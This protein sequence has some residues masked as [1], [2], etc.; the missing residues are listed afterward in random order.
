MRAEHMGRAAA[1]AMIL[2]CAVPVVAGADG[3]GTVAADVF[4]FGG[5]ARIDA[6]A[7]G[8]ALPG[9]A[10]ALIRNPAAL[11]DASGTTV[12]VDYRNWYL[13][14]YA[15]HA[16]V[17]T[18]AFWGRG[19]L[20]VGV[21]RLSEGEVRDL[22]YQHLAY[23]E[24]FDN[25]SL[26]IAVG[27]GAP[28]PVLERVDAGLS[29]LF[30]TR[31]LLSQ[32][33][34]GLGVGGGLAAGLWDDALRLGGSFRHIGDVEGDIEGISN[35]SPWSVTAG[36][37]VTIDRF[38]HPGASATVTADVVKERN[39]DAG[40][41]VGLEVE[42][43]EALALRVGYDSMVEDAPVRFGLGMRG[44]RADVGLVYTHHEALGSTAGLSVTLSLG[45]E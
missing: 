13:D 24:A 44:G 36:A 3:V 7:A 1:I 23:G 32:T 29:A 34:S 2:T 4:A 17:T 33:A 16:G 37:C 35:V 41:R 40:G 26:G 42:I 43:A 19:A 28:L 39:V 27:Y 25:G 31:T 21:V 11:A 14:T 20:G 30:L 18:P 8:V 45:S 12:A 15:A 10:D 6:L 38:V 9:S 22:D 5:S